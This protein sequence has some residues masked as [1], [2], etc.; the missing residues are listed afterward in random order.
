MASKRII[1]EFEQMPDNQDLKLLVELA[2]KLKATIIQ[3]Q[4]PAANTNNEAWEPLSLQ[5]GRKPDDI[6]AL[7][8]RETDIEPL[9]E[10]F[11]E[12]EPADEL[13]KML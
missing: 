6:G 10:L 4:T 13:C 12:E 2:R 5:I 3:E 7:A 11:S 1:L 9:I 8:I